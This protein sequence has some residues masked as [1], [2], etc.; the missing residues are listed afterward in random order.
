MDE[1]QHPDEIERLRAALWADGTGACEEAAGHC[2]QCAEDVLYHR[3]LRD[4]FRR[5]DD[6][7]VPAITMQRAL[8]VAREEAD[9]ATIAWIPAYP[10]GSFAG[11]RGAATAEVHVACRAAGLGLEMV[12]CPSGPSGRYAL[13]GQALRDDATPATGLEVTL[14]VDRRRTAATRT[15][16]FGEFAFDPARGDRFGVRLGSGVDAAHVE[17]VP[18]GGAR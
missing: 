15:D 5:R 17:I 6:A 8:S 16:A 9:A 7:E 18:G 3:R 14:F 10:A 4:A 13:S 1:A 12:L 2:E 11:Q